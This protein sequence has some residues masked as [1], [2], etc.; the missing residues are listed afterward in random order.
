VSRAVSQAAA[1]ITLSRDSY[2]LATLPE[3]IT[4]IAHVIG[5]DGKPANDATVTFSISPPGQTTVTRQLTTTDGTAIWSD[6]PLT[7]PGAVSGRG[8]VTVL[9]TVSDGE[10]IAASAEFTYR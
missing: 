5:P 7:L 3:S 6:Y 1:T 9:A 10:Q 4:M 2:D 8:L